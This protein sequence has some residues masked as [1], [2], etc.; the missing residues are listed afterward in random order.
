MFKMVAP[1]PPKK[2]CQSKHK[3]TDNR[4]KSFWK[5]ATCSVMTLA[6]ASRVTSANASDTKFTDSFLLYLFLWH[7]MKGIGGNY[8]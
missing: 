3:R 1:A 2:L 7:Q 5:N 8:N 4:R 6:G